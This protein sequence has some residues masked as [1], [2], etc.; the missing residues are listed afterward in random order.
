V[1]GPA[2][3]YTTAQKDWLV[4]RAKARQQALE[5]ANKDIARAVQI[6][7]KLLVF[8]RQVFGTVHKETIDG[9]NFISDLYYRQEDFRAAIAVDEE[10]ISITSNIYGKDHWRVHERKYERDRLAI[11]AKHTRQNRTLWLQAATLRGQGW[12][13]ANTNP[14]TAL[15]LAGKSAKLFEML[16]GKDNPDY[17]QVLL[18]QANAYLAKDELA[19]AEPLL[20]E[21]A[22]L[23]ASYFGKDS[24]PYADV[25]RD[26]GFLYTELGEHHRAN[27]AYRIAQETYE[28]EFDK[29]GLKLGRLLRELSNNYQNLRE[30]SRAKEL[31]RRSVDLIVEHQ[32]K[33]QLGYP[34]SLQVLGNA[35][36][37]LNELEQAEAVYREA[38]AAVDRLKSPAPMVSAALRL[39][40]ANV[41]LDKNGHASEALKLAKES[42]NLVLA[43][44]PK[45]PHAINALTLIAAAQ[46]QLKDYDSAHEAARQAVEQRQQRVGKENSLTQEY[47]VN[48]IEIDLAWSRDLA[49]T[50]KVEEGRGVLKRLQETLAA[51]YGPEHL[52]AVTA[53][54]AMDGLSKYAALDAEGR[55]RIDEANQAVEK[56]SKPEVTSPNAIPLLEQGKKVIEEL[57]GRDDS[58][59]ARINYRLGEAQLSVGRPDLAQPLF[60]Q[61][62]ELYRQHYGEKEAPPLVI[63][64]LFAL[65]SSHLEQA[66][67][68]EAIPLLVESRELCKKHQGPASGDY[69]TLTNELAAALISIGEFEKARFMLMENLATQERAKGKKSQQ[70]GETLATLFWL[71]ARSNELDRAEEYFKEAD[72]VLRA[73]PVSH[74]LVSLTLNRG[75]YR[76]QY[77]DASLALPLLEWT[78]DALSKYHSPQQQRLRIPCLHGLAMAF[79]D[80]GDFDRGQETLGEAIEIQRTKFAGRES[81]YQH[82]LVLLSALFNMRAAVAYNAD[83]M[84]E[85]ISAHESALD[86]W[87]EFVPED[88]WRVRAALLRLEEAK[89]LA[90]LEPEVRKKRLEELKAA[91]QRIKSMPPD[92]ALVEAPKVGNEFIKAMEAT[93]GKASLGYC[94]LADQLIPL[95]LQANQLA[96]AERLSAEMLAITNKLLGEESALVARAYY[97]EG[98]VKRWK[99]QHFHAANN[100]RF[101]AE[102]YAKTVGEQS[103]DYGLARYHFGEEMM[104][105]GELAVAEPALQKAHA[106]LSQYQVEFPLEYI[107]CLTAYGRTCLALNDAER[108]E[109]LLVRAHEQ[110][111]VI[112]GGQTLP[113]TLAA[114]RLGNLYAATGAYDRAEPLLREAVEEQRKLLGERS[115]YYA[116]SL[117]SLANLLRDRGDTLLPGPLYQQVIEIYDSQ[118][119][120][121]SSGVVEVLLERGRMHLARGDF[122]PAG[123]DFERAA[124]MAA[125]LGSA[126]G[127]LAVDCLASRGDL[128]FQSGDKEQAADFYNQYYARAELTA[129]SRAGLMTEAQQLEGMKRLREVLGWLLSLGPRDEELESAYA[130]VLAWKGAVHTRQSRLREVRKDDKL[131]EQFRLWEQLT[132]QLGTLALR[133]PFPEEREIWLEQVRQLSGERDALERTL[134]AAAAAKP[135]SI[136]TPVELAAALPADAALVDVIQFERRTPDKDK[137][138]QWLREARLVAVVS[139]QGQKITFVDLGAAEEA[140]EEVDAWLAGVENNLSLSELTALGH[141][142]KTRL[143]SPLEKNLGDATIV[144]VSPDGPLTRIPL[145]ALPAAMPDT[146]LLEECAFILAPVPALLPELI[147]SATSSDTGALLAMGDVDYGGSAGSAGVRRSS[148]SAAEGTRSWLLSFTALANTGPEVDGIASLFEELAGGASTTPLKGDKANEGTFRQQAAQARWLHLATHA[149]F[150]PDMMESALAGDGSKA[151]VPT[152]SGERP[153][154]AV[155]FHPGLLSGLALAGANVANDPDEDDGVLSALE[156]AALD[157]TNVELAVLSACQTAQGKEAGGEGVLGLQRA[158]QVAGARSVVSTLWPISDAGTRI[159]MMR[160]YM[161][162]WGKQMSKLEALREAQLWM[163]SGAR[164][165]KEAGESPETISLNADKLPPALLHPSFWAP[166]VLSGDWR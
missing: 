140:A 19:L 122:K 15:E 11:M 43:T 118:G 133:V 91:G 73:L 58:S 2:T 94:D 107:N 25:Q 59:L 52:H 152:A 117:I 99:Q 162:L 157:L 61:A 119:Y 21:A 108:A 65:A 67:Y 147:A 143:W 151:D 29:K 126:A 30:Y 7:E 17:A 88:H 37:L 26:Y 128:A 41:L 165:A 137:P 104:L 164:A 34:A 150:A 97:L 84:A 136:P 138:G 4:E 40:L 125:K 109:T 127:G 142:L 90:A 60:L 160:F 123:A 42:Q 101:A 54:M 70:Y 111:R 51:S 110:A 53:E 155:K 100:F 113:R 45:A 148:S 12:A 23:Q 57:Y 46:R 106:I 38:I 135:P 144:L 129:F 96:E 39:G 93:L 69:S 32:G 5:L 36:R 77:G 18:L 3:P 156:V 78:R 68:S 153:R 16:L 116:T 1:D 161:N 83:R 89:K 63:N 121:E 112:D 79:T 27:R 80:T 98:M 105:G 76:V 10:I 71:S 24:L 149:F 6:G 14:A 33:G 75:L 13:Q 159:L 132:G 31:A 50:G 47:V 131:R 72:A 85:F 74:G 120:G 48:L 64:L 163:L 130:K 28:R 82:E 139:R 141:A 87:K 49:A 154:L 56:A 55:R 22:R 20:A 92:E 102:I 146:F 44:S 145:G 114:L 95:Y 166:F 66:N 9:L 86:H 62:V 115:A 8:D 124:A 134:A 81:A 35:L 103:V 158:F